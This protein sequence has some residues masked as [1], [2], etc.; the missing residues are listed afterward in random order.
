MG[1][2]FTILIAEDNPGDVALLRRAL[3]KANIYNPVQVVQS[4]KEAIEYLEGQGRFANRS[5]HPFPSVMFTDLEMPLVNG[6]D[7]LRWLKTR[8]E[9]SLLPVIVLT[10]S[11]VKADVQLAYQLGA[12]SY[13]VKP[14][15]FNELIRVVRL[16]FDY[17]SCCEKPV[18]PENC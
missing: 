18:V 14:G 10:S 1:G 4:G 6:F 15:S 8:D 3:L 2:N 9:K 13:I 11:C 5:E 16:A 12:N 7:V 17:W